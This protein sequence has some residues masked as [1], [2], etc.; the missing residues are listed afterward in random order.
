MRKLSCGPFWVVGP[1]T[2]ARAIV[3]LKSTQVT[4]FVIKMCVKFLKGVWRKLL[5]RSFPQ[6]KYVN[7]AFAQEV[8]PIKL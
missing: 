6:K 5:L 1:K 7:E 3:Y 2:V 8:S 4:N